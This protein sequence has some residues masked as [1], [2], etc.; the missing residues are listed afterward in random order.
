M[1]MIINESNYNYLHQREKV[2]ANNYNLNIIINDNYPVVDD[3]N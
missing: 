1:T 3:T 2:F